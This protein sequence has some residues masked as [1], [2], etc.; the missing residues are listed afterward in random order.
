MVGWVG[1]KGGVVVGSVVGSLP[2]FGRA[3][4]SMVTVERGLM[5]DEAGGDVWC[6]EGVKLPEDWEGLSAT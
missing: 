3:L 1:C 5:M 6:I 4:G 2:E